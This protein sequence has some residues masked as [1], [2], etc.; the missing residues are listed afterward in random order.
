MADRLLAETHL[1]PP[2][3]LTNLAFRTSI[4]AAIDQFTD[5][6]RPGRSGEGWIFCSTV[7]LV[8]CAN[9][10]GELASL[11]VIIERDTDRSK[12]FT[13]PITLAPFDPN[14]SLSLYREWAYAHFGLKQAVDHFRAA[15]ADHMLLSGDTEFCVTMRLDVEIS[16]KGSNVAVSVDANGAILEQSIVDRLALS[17]RGNRPRP[18]ITS[19]S[20][21]PEPAI[22]QW[23]VPS[24]A[25][26]HAATPDAKASSPSAPPATPATFEDAR[27][28]FD[29]ESGVN[30]IV[31]KAGR[32]SKAVGGVPSRQGFELFKVWNGGTS[33]STPQLIDPAT[34][35]LREGLA[36]KMV[37]Q[38]TT[39]RGRKVS[40]VL[41]FVPP[42]ACAAVAHVRRS[43]SCSCRSEEEL[44]DGAFFLANCIGTA[45]IFLSP[46]HDLYLAYEAD[47]AHRGYARAV[48]YTTH[49][50][51][52][53]RTTELVLASVPFGAPQ[54]AAVTRELLTVKALSTLGSFFTKEVMASNDTTSEALESPAVANSVSE[55]RRAKP[56]RARGGKKIA[57]S[58]LP[59][60]KPCSTPVLTP[61]RAQSSVKD[62]S[63]TSCLESPLRENLAD[64]FAKAAR[65]AAEQ[66]RSTASPSEPVPELLTAPLGLFAVAHRSPTCIVEADRADQLVILVVADAP[67]RDFVAAAETAAANLGFTAPI[68]AQNADNQKTI[69]SFN[70]TPW[71]TLYP[72]LPVN[73]L[74]MTLSDML[75][76]DVDAYKNPSLLLDHAPGDAWVQSATDALATKSGGCVS[77]LPDSSSMHVRPPSPSGQ[78]T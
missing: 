1:L 46:G 72:H 31:G 57:P 12:D 17:V 48:L 30:Y 41:H 44:V 11:V 56:R 43:T 47:P 22:A 24:F 75:A 14:P 77:L 25:R 19:A 67:K 6:V 10:D 32:L 36:Q 73:V 60:S 15:L 76:Q 66:P 62:V 18:A 21:W 42:C 70:D 33:Q 63:A 3:E 68:V 7:T 78:E 49:G 69:T 54:S 34:Q 29:D 8:P 26:S 50:P 20:F 38:P 5:L 23:Y 28:R 16:A 71:D 39:Q 65:S 53:R 4:L 40:V 55:V 13:W 35:T 52:L 59:T 9:G 51:G 61:A 45:L 58:P 37:F 64:V 27:Y 74:I 2:G